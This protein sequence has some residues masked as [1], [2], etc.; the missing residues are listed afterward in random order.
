MTHKSYTYEVLSNNFDKLKF[1]VES[2]LLGN[3][4]QERDVFL[5]G[6]MVAQSFPWVE[7]HHVFRAICVRGD[8]EEEFRKLS[9]DFQSFVDADGEVSD[10]SFSDEQISELTGFAKFLCKIA[11]SDFSE[12]SYLNYFGLAY[13]FLKIN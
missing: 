5:Y 13:A 1:S 6:L 11:G 10:K 8:Q 9:R 2:V 7:P 4:K 12:N 3:P